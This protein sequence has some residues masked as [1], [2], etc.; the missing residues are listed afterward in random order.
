M[1][2]FIALVL[3]SLIGVAQASINLKVDLGDFSPDS[4]QPITL[5]L[6]TPGTSVSVYSTTIAVNA[7]GE[8]S[9][10][11]AAAESTFDIRI[12]ASHWLSLTFR[13]VRVFSGTGG[14][15]LEA[16]LVNGDVDG[17]DAVTVFD[18]D[19]L[20][21]AF[22]TT[23]VDTNWNP[24][25][26]LD[27]DSAVTAFDYDILS[28]NFDAQS[29]LERPLATEGNS[30]ILAFPFTTPSTLSPNQVHLLVSSTD[31]AAGSVTAPA[32]L[33]ENPPQVTSFD[34]ATAPSSAVIFSATS[35]GIPPTGEPPSVT[36]QYWD[37]PVNAAFQVTTS[38]GSAS[39]QVVQYSTQATEAWS[40][41]PLRSLGFDHVVTSYPTG[42]LGCSFV[43][44]AA[45]FGTVGSPTSVTITPRATCGETNGRLAG[46]PFTIALY[47]GQVYQFRALAKGADLTGTTVTSDKPI[48]VLSGNQSAYVPVNASV[49]NALLEQM[50]STD[51][52]GTEFV[53]TP[54]VGRPGEDVV[55]ILASR[56][57]TV[58]TVNGV[59]RST[60]LQRGD[61][62][63]VDTSEVIAPGIVAVLASK[64]VLVAQILKGKSLMNPAIIGLTGPTMVLVP[65]VSHF[66]ASSRFV[67][68]G[69]LP[70]PDTWTHHVN[71]VLQSAVV[72]PEISGLRDGQLVIENVNG[73]DVDLL[74]L[75]ATT[76]T[77]IPYASGLWHASLE[78]PG[79]GTYSFTAAVGAKIGVVAYG[80]NQYDTY[81]FQGCATADY[82]GGMAPL[83]VAP[84]N[85]VATVLQ[86]N[87]AINDFTVDV[88]WND[89]SN[90]EEGFFVQRRLNGITAWQTL[91]VLAPNTTQYTD[92]TA[93]ADKDYLYRVCAIRDLDAPSDVAPV[94][95]PP[96]FPTNLTT[97][98]L[99][100]DKIKITWHDA[101]AVET[102]YRV[103]RFY[104]GDWNPVGTVPAGST[105]FIDE[106]LSPETAYQYRVTALR[107][108]LHGRSAPTLSVTTPKQPPAAPTG[109]SATAAS[110]A[111]VNLTWTDA[112]A[113]EDSFQIE[114]RQG[115]G[116]WTLVG[117]RPA[118]FTSYPDSTVVGATTYTYRVR[119]VNSDGESSY[120]NEAATTPPY[121][122]IP[123]IP[124]L[125][126]TA[127][128]SSQIRLDWTDTSSVETGFTIQ[129]APGGTTNW[130]TVKDAPANTTTWTNDGLTP[131]TS[132][133]YR[134][135]AYNVSGNSN[136]SDTAKAIT[137]DPA[138]AP[139]YVAVNATSESSIR[140]TWS[141][142]SGATSYR[143]YRSISPNVAPS[144][145]NLVATTPASQSVAQNY[146][147][148]GLV[149]NQTYYYMVTCL[150]G[151]SESVASLED[152][153]YP[154]LEAV[155]WNAPAS[156]I[157]TAVKSEANSY[158]ENPAT[159]PNGN[160]VVVCPDNSTLD[161][162]S[163]SQIQNL[164]SM[165][166]ASQTMTLDGL[167]LPTIFDTGIVDKQV[168]GAYRKVTAQ[169]TT[170]SYTKMGASA[171]FDIQPYGSTSYTLG[172][173]DAPH[174][175][176]GLEADGIGGVEAGVQFSKAGMVNGVSWQDRW[177][178]YL[179]I[180]DGRPNQYGTPLSQ[181]GYGANA[182]S[183]RPRL[184]AQNGVRVY[185][186]LR[187]NLNKRLATFNVYGHDSFFGL[188]Y[189]QSYSC[190]ARAKST[191]INGQGR[192][193][194][195]RMRYVVSLAQAPTSTVGA[196]SFWNTP[197]AGW[198]KKY[199]PNGSFFK[200]TGVSQPLLHAD[201]TGYDW[202]NDH[203]G[204]SIVRFSAQ[205]CVTTSRTTSGDGFPM[206]VIWIQ[207]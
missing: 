89:A 9:V 125:T 193:T 155:P 165:S 72:G 148:Y 138:S 61:Y 101:S 37:Q 70:G 64:P 100:Y 18:Y 96:N 80:G 74:K 56:N 22:D 115:A 63:D 38:R 79:P 6:K 83:P 129:R 90:D 150:S 4:T 3:T 126:A 179:R 39:V 97:E 75:P 127:I 161:D 12:K 205:P 158:A 143:V 1:R 176:L 91:E 84:T 23:P 157:L 110:Y 60:A 152:S 159:I 82:N 196:L 207:H 160:T 55:R 178:G 162:Q 139:T 131:E 26:D 197:P 66:R 111:Q 185:V 133:T 189:I 48:A 154:N 170:A 99:A 17:D 81:S 7:A 145:A 203:P 116:A 25:A 36:L 57:N 33:L 11:Y 54:F 49:A 85:V 123:P 191:R 103:D 24:N 192:L 169:P 77:P 132:Y 93:L 186:I 98:V 177:G 204:W 62:I 95:T 10:P 5:E 149:A 41:L 35:S 171:V 180:S 188:I 15:V 30:F 130:T 40:A 92:A 163:V 187:I 200:G 137:T 53:T 190:T 87:P 134:V 69:S 13:A 106:G 76:F 32:G 34:F 112:S 65:S 153:H 183:T 164:F 2:T 73:V 71:F 42:A 195:A 31:E 136:W 121:P 108:M 105:Q 120:S 135:C 147:D 45:P 166:L 122:P 198:P 117:T 20:A 43:T 206:D 104:G 172:P 27:G 50:P 28:A 124:S 44:I 109:L 167:V 146:D 8:V 46:L 58:V 174:A 29:E 181:R 14:E 52:W 68:P 19:A 151:T 86:P 175:Y 94:G 113:N 168:Q 128:S 21:Q 141:T 156:V 173:T 119:A 16:T 202:D 182:N 140:V 118:D 107:G 114:R 102:Q 201:G 47:A 144:T 59:V 67:A 88:T 184:N 199:M 142:V 78:L 194:N 51:L